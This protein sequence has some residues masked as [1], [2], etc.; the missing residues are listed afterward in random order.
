L[1]LCRCEDATPVFFLGGRSIKCDHRV[2]NIQIRS[3]QYTCHH[4]PQKVYIL[5]FVKALEGI[6]NS[7]YLL[8][9]QKRKLWIRTWST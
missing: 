6:L 8:A 2:D 5:L 4:A 1:K 3:R 7:F 9:R